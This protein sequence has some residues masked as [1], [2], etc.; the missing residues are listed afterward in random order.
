MKIF[1]VTGNNDKYSEISSILSEYNIEYEQFS[2]D[3]NEEGVSLEEI[4]RLKAREAYKS[5]KKPLIVDD[6]GIFFTSCHN[7]PGHKAKRVFQELGFDGIMKAL[8]GKSREAAFRTVI[9]YNDGSEMKLFQGEMKGSILENPGP[10][11]RKD[12]PYERIFVPEGKEE[13]VSCMSAEEKNKISHRA[14]AARKFARWFSSK[15]K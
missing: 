2:L 14:M 15:M 7:F 1:I 9:C 5:I 13:P 3:V 10:D 6:T 11:A 8:K 12:L 4:A